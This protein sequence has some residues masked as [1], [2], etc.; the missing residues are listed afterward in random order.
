MTEKQR[1]D[2]L[3]MPVGWAGTDLQV[4]GDLDSLEGDFLPP[5]RMLVASGQTS[6]LHLSLAGQLAVHISLL[7]PC[8][9]AHLPAHARKLW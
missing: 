9:P 3:H 1:P 5:L 6:S 2:R 7:G 8:D 4:R